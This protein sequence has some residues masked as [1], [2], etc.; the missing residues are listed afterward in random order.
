MKVQGRHF[1]TPARISTP[2]SL[3]NLFQTINLRPAINLRQAINLRYAI[4]L[5]QRQL[6][7]ADL[8]A[9]VLLVSHLLR[10]HLFTDTT[11]QTRSHLTGIVYKVVLK[12]SMPAH[13]R[14][15]LL[16]VSNNKGSVDGFARELT[17]TKRLYHTFVR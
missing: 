15:L 11:A 4:N 9:V 7:S 6:G 10:A 17:L 5:R 16:L 3:L 8:L 2:H 13:I 1:P 14:Q 12:K